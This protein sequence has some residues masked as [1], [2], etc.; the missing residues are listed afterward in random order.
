METLSFTFGVLSV[1]AVII[2][3]VIVMGI[4]KVLKQQNKINIWK[5]YRLLLEYSL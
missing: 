5:H 1:V 2:L 4:V 3:T